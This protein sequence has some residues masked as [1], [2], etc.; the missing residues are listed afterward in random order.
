LKIRLH[1][2]FILFAAAAIATGNYIWFLLAFAAVTLHEMGHIGVAFHFKLRVEKLSITPLGEHALIADM[3]SLSQG[4]RIAIVLAGPLVSLALFAAFKK[5]SPDFALA[6]LAVLILNI[7]PAYPL[8]GG[9]LLHIIMGNSLG[10]LRANRTATAL[11]KATS[12]VLLAAGLVLVVLFPFNISLVC[13]AVFLRRNLEVERIRM[14]SDFFR[15]FEDNRFGGKSA[16]RVRFYC[17]GPDTRLIRI[18]ERLCWDTYGVFAVKIGD[19]ICESVDEG[20]VLA[21]FRKNG[22]GYVRELLE[23]KWK[24]LREEI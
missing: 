24:R 23:E 4:P 6:N 7:L 8:D 15:H 20:A 19:T 5:A 11:T 12:A 10:V 21:H 18:I 17:V 13:I 14:A 2:V 9:R 16:L 1:P 22:G 3:E